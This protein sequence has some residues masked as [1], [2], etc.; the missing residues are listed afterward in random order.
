MHLRDAHIC[1]QR[2]CGH[3]YRNMI[4]MT[5]SAWH[6]T[7][8]RASTPEHFSASGVD[9]CVSSW[10]TNIASP[11]I[12]RGEGSEKEECLM[13]KAPPRRA[14]QRRRANNPSGETELMSCRVSVKSSRFQIVSWKSPSSFPVHISI[15]AAGKACRTLCACGIAQCASDS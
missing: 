9:E 11:V 14:V 2:L 1:I 15:L 6:R 4:H 3:S 7:S 5:S 8:R 10:S 13:G 12:C